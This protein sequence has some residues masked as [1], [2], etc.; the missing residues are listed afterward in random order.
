MGRFINCFTVVI[1]DGH[2]SGSNLVNISSSG[3]DS[4]MISKCMCS[5]YMRSSI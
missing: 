5:V 2:H 1:Q 4:K 3:R